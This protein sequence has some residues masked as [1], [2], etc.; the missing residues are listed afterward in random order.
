MELNRRDLL[1]VLGLAGLGV[2][3]GGVLAGCTTSGGGAPV[4]S[5]NADLDLWTHDPGYATF[6]TDAATDAALVGGSAWTFGVDVTSIAPA[7]IVSRL[8]TQAVAQRPLPQLAGLVIDQFPRVMRA[9]IAENLF[10]DL[11]SLTE[12]LG[13]RLLKTQPYSVDGK[14]YALE[15]DNSVSVMF[16]RADLFEQLGIPDDVGTWEE[17]LEI[18]A[19]VA[20]DTGRAI[21]MVANGDNGSIVN[22]FTQLLLQRGGSLYDADG[23]L[24]VVSDESVEVLELMA[25][26]VRSGAFLPLSDPYGGAV[27][28]ALKENQLIAT[29]MPN[30]YE[31]YGLQA[32]VP[33]QSGRW[34]ARTIPRFTGGGHIGST[35]G[36]TAFAVL[37]DQPLTDAATDLLRRTY[38]SE[39]GQLARYHAGAYMPTLV[40]LYQA[41]RFQQITDDYLGGQRVF[42][43][44][45]AA[46]MDM[47]AFYQAAGAS[48]LR[49]SLGGPILRAINGQ[50]SAEEALTAGVHAYERQVQQ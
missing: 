17:L 16:Y 46:A 4:L 18:G 38:L 49:D 25:A 33:D 27:A 9:D 42:E 3:G 39:D 30:W 36:G 43:V 11:T 21:G 14:V 34:R 26:G 50:A 28:A 23:N 41:T 31:V 12:P 20:A 7:D 44:Y 48:V 47:P 19:G 15:S 8:I 35:L 10:V 29:V 32:N 45:A 37:K 24:T 6:F 40:D 2:A 22:G 1:K 13:D 5:G